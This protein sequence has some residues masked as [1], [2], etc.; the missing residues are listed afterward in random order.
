MELS[1]RGEIL[2]KSATPNVTVVRIARPE[3]G[4][5]LYEIDS[6]TNSSLYNDLHENVVVN[7]TEGDVLVLNCG[8]IEQFGSPY[9]SLIVTVRDELED[10]NARMI[11]CCV[12]D[13]MQECLE[14]LQGDRKF[15]TVDTEYRIL[16]QLGVA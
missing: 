14:I 12:P 6:V 15:E 1:R 7:L 3:V 4:Q 16:K 13:L 10:R 2:L 8:L 9:F 5:E 11:L